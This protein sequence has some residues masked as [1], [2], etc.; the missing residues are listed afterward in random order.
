MTLEM[1]VG[2]AT[3][4]LELALDAGKV[5]GKYAGRYGEYPV[6]GTLKDRTL[7]F[8]FTMSADGSPMTISFH[9]EVALDGQSITGNASMAEMGDARFT[10]IRAK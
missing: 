9:G 2:T 5:T 3:P 10:A 4:S 1:S 7:D 6:T 8:S